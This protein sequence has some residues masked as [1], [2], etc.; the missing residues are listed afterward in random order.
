MHEGSTSSLATAAGE[1]RRAWTLSVLAPLTLAAGCATP[2]QP[3]ATAI[4]AAVPAAPSGP[5]AAFYRSELAALPSNDAL[6][7][8]LKGELDRWMRD[9]GHAALVEDGRLDQVSFDLACVVVDTRSPAAELVTFLTAY[10]GMVEPQPSIVLISGERG[11]EA[12]ALEQLGQQMGAVPATSALRQVGIGVC[13]HGSAWSAVVALLEHGLTIEPLPRSLPS[14]GRTTLAGTVATTYSAPE[15]LVTGPAGAVHRVPTQ[16]HGGRFKAELA[17]HLGDGAYQVEVLAEDQRGPT[18]LANFPLYCG[19][20]PPAR[21]DRAVL[22]AAPEGGTSASPEAIEDLLFELMNRDR[23]RSGLP[24]LHR[25]GR[26]NQIARAYSQEMAATGEV[27]HYSRRSGNAVDR[28]RA[29]KITPMPR[30]VAENV[31]RDYSAES[32]ERGF[33]TSPGHRANVLSADVTHV[34]VGVA[35]GSKGDGDE[36][37]IFVTQVFVGWGQ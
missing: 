6:A 20:S 18:V 14:A 37:P 8:E 3:A 2:H 25:D 17:C 19:V 24:R 9:K 7:R 30:V 23:S 34:G 10:Y 5:A 12:S 26:L 33:M 1:G 4:P 36:A 28:V 16:V 15:V 13:H 21:L 29:A 22:V 31:G 11:A 32:I 35:I 27:A